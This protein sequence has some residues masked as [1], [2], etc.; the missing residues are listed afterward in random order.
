MPLE[1]A[2][3]ERQR[4]GGCGVKEAAQRIQ[5]TVKNTNWT[6]NQPQ[7]GILVELFVVVE[8]I[9]WYSSAAVVL[10]VLSKHSSWCRRTP[11]SPRPLE[12]LTC[13]VRIGC[14]ARC[15]A[16]GLAC[17][18]QNS[19]SPR[20]RLAPNSMSEGFLVGVPV[21]MDQ[22]AHELSGGSRAL[23]IGLVKAG[24]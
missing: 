4:I 7:I 23:A 21:G 13:L 15:S 17:G 20:C 22:V 2:E 16:R 10:L 9:P 24:S 6:T 5:R 8:V 14:H 18:H 11:R 12:P 3:F 1:E 19:E